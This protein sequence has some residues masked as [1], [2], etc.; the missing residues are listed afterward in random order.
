MAEGR[1]RQVVRE[2][3]D[4]WFKFF[5]KYQIWLMCPLWHTASIFAGRQ[6]ERPL[7][8]RHFE[9]KKKMTATS[10]QTCMIPLFRCSFGRRIRF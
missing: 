8:G 5:Q 1:T 2:L 3:R 9:R 4:V 6:D 10:A 7:A